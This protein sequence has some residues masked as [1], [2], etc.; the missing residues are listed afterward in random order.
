M[1]NDSVYGEQS[2]FLYDT[3]SKLECKRISQKVYR[4]LINSEVPLRKY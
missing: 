1:L 3:L 2:E 4:T